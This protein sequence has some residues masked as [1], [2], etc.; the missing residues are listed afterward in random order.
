MIEELPI[1][2]SYT[3]AQALEDGVLIDVSKTA[4]EAGFVFP[5]AVSN[6]LWSRYIQPSEQ[7]KQYGQSIE[8]RLWDVIWLAR[9]KA[10]RSS[11]SRFE[12]KVIFQDGPHPKDKHQPIIIA[13]CGPGDD[14]R[15]VVTLM[16][17]EDD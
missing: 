13:N 6:T 17:P 15:P 9:I 8:G 2:S 11:G 5:V 12:Y 1:I 3:R 14:M 7:A 16:L 4:R 10:S